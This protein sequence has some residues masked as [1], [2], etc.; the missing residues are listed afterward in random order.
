[1][2][3]RIQNILKGPLC[4]D[5]NE[6]EIRKYTLHNTN[7]I[8][9]RFA[10]ILVKS[11]CIIK[12]SLI[13]MGTHPFAFKN[14]HIV[15][16]LFSLL[17]LTGSDALHI[18]TTEKDQI[19]RVD[20]LTFDCDLFHVT[21]STFRVGDESSEYKVTLSGYQGKAG[22]Y[23]INYLNSSENIKLGTLYMISG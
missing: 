19:L 23:C 8:V 22:M 21:Y 4:F 12:Q 13:N 9:I 10:T 2:K 7:K 6:T 3:S 5:W 16:L 20:I 11:Y 15:S 1:M 14:Y 17:H 18:L